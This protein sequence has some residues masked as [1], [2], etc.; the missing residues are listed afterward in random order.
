MYGFEI[1][2]EMETTSLQKLA[3][4]G[5]WMVNPMTFHAYVSF[6]PKLFLLLLKN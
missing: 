1:N 3:M 2:V 5:M 6:P 4:D